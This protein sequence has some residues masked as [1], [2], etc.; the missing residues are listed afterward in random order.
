MLIVHIKDVVA[1][2]VGRGRVV[3]IF[4]LCSFD[5]TFTLRRRFDASLQV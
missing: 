2:Y 1:I 4:I 3:R 5:K